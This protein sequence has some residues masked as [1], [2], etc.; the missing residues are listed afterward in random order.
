MELEWAIRETQTDALYPFRIDA[1]D[2]MLIVDWQPL[3]QAILEDIAKGASIACISAAFHNTLA[4]TIVEVARRVGE[5]TIALSG[6]CF[7]NRYLTEQTVRRLRDAGFSPQWHQRV[8][9]ND[10]GIA[11]GQILAAAQAKE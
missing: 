10:G 6:G 8:P 2:G 5:P 3:I 9:P 1:K 4:E 7:Q 11:L